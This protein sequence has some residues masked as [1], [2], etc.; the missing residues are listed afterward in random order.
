MHLHLIFPESPLIHV[1]RDGRDVVCSLLTMNWFDP[2]TGKP[3]D[4]T[5]DCR[6]AAE[7][8]AASVTRGRQAG[9]DPAVAPRYYEIRYEDIVKE[10]VV[11]LKKLFEFIGEPW[12][13]RVLAFHEVS[14]NL[15]GESSAEQ[16]SQPL[17]SRALGRWKKD[18]T[19]RQKDEIKSVAGD[20]LIDLGYVS[21]KS[22]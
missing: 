12:D 11:T 15:A 5:R 22:W 7:Y 14:R 9:N 18:L 3:L 13:E 17:N 6:K 21:D 1:I 8:W 16:V 10:P 19:P 20:L 2:Q 4:Y